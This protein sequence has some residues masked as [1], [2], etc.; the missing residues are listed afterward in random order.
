MVKYTLNELLSLPNLLTYFRFVAAPFLLWLAWS[1]KGDAFLIL[2]AATFLSDALDGLAARLLN[3]QSELG[4]FLD[5]A[6]DLLIYGTMAISI[7]WL[8][9]DIVQREIMYVILIIISFSLPVIIGIIKFHNFTSYHT[10]LVKGA[11]I[12]TGIAFFILFVFDIAWPF[13]IA[14]FVCLLAALEEI[15]IT[16]YLTKMRSNVRSLWHVM[17]L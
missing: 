6:G 2:L 1:D 4:A 3:Q 8:W 5:S 16:F 14:A 13:R 10:W 11:V 17:S 15:A 7:W 9:P 12:V